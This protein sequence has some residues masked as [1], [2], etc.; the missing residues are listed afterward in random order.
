MLVS[1]TLNSPIENLEP[2]SVL[3]APDPSQ[4]IFRPISSADRELLHQIKRAVAREREASQV[5]LQYLLDVERRRLYLKR[6]FA[7]LF[8]FCVQELG[9]CA[10]SAHLRIQGMRL[11]RDL[12]P[13]ARE[14]VSKKLADGRI[15]LSQLSNV[16]T[17]SRQ[18]ATHRVAPERKLEILSKLE[19]RPTRES[20]Q[21][22]LKELGLE[23]ANHERLRVKGPD[24]VEL[25]LTLTADAVELLEE[26][27]ALTSHSNPEGRNGEAI[28]AALR[29][30]VERA[31]RER[32]L[33]AARTT[34]SASS[35]SG[36]QSE[37]LQ[38]T[39]PEGSFGRVPENDKTKAE[40]EPEK[41]AEHRAAPGPA[42]RASLH[43]C[44]VASELKSAIPVA[45]RRL[46]WSRDGARCT[47]Y[48]KRTGRRCDGT[49]YLEIDH[50]IPRALGG[51]HELQNL[52]LLCGG[53]HRLRHF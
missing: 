19:G 31:R 34:E 46:V 33:G 40:R 21:I 8:D 10:G 12:A 18:V 53:H 44:E 48:D 16:Q 35:R 23:G 26:W 45:L 27:K 11:L 14:E 24:R 13:P 4:P 3:P 17:Y 29:V 30:A 42:R 7:S 1:S 22:I 41:I 43:A 51:R 25:T 38:Q 50:I 5:V 9:Y 37:E 32:G 28:T 49:R 39:Q 36:G 52:R 2:A 47:F 20:Q 6:G 15:T